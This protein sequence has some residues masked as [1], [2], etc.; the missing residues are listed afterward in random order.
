MLETSSNDTHAAIPNIVGAS[1]LVLRYIMD[2][3]QLADRIGLD[4]PLLRMCEKYDIP[5]L[6]YSV[7]LSTR[8][9]HVHAL[10]E[11][12]RHFI[13]ASRLDCAQA[14]FEM[15]LTINHPS[16]VPSGMPG[17]SGFNVKVADQ[18][19]PKWVFAVMKAWTDVLDEGLVPKQAEQ[20]YSR[21]ASRLCEILM[22]RE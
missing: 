21:F 16:H 12:L 3:S 4:E 17:S 1:L 22:K 10:D 13:W 7:M 18:L 5:G 20:Y 15:L 9:P 8:P 11:K 14:A 19:R 6:A 2:R